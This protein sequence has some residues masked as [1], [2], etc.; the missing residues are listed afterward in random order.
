MVV[1]IN[2]LQDTLLSIEIM[3]LLVSSLLK[4]YNNSVKLGL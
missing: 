3:P 4:S 2:N 1:A